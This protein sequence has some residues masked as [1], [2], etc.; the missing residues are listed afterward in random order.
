[1]A[2]MLAV[3]SRKIAHAEFLTC[4]LRFPDGPE[5]AARMR[6]ADGRVRSPIIYVGDLSRLGPTYVLM[7]TVD[8]LKRRFEQVAKTTGATLLVFSGDGGDC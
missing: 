8:G 1:M 5:V 3:T 2:G 4:I 6:Q 7:D